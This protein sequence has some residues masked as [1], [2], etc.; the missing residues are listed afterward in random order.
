MPLN[1]IGT[2]KEGL[3]ADA[4][5]LPHYSRSSAN[6]YATISGQSVPYA[7]YTIRVAV[8]PC[9]ALSANPDEAI[10]ACYCNAL[11]LA[12]GTDAMHIAVPVIT[13]EPDAKPGEQD[14]R[15]A[16]GSVALF[17]KDKITE[18][19]V[20]LALPKIDSFGA[21]TKLYEDVGRYVSEA[22]S[23]VGI[24][25]DACGWGFGDDNYGNAFDDGFGKDES[26]SQAD[27]FPFIEKPAE[28]K[29][30]EPAEETPERPSE[31]RG[32]RSRLIRHLTDVTDE[33]DDTPQ[34]FEVNNFALPRFAKTGMPRRCI[35]RKSAAFSGLRVDTED[36]FSKRLRR[37][38]IAKGM[39]DVAV[40]K[41]ANLSRQHWSKII[42]NENYQP[43]KRT[44]VAL[45]VSLRL[46]LDETKDLLLSAGFALS[47]SF[48]FDLVIEYF[49]TQQNYDIYLINE[50]LFKYEQPLLG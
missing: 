1:Y 42:S 16:I 47:R 50:V 38:V 6:A 27:D 18:P 29:E 30:D 15:I 36:S 14:V 21:G 25:G 23:G 44:V 8:S 32:K 45:A 3:Y 12:Y 31:K 5:V 48:T 46:N 41:R 49:I 19:T 20:Y 39:D 24:Y 43:S 40:Y 17:L 7:D 9:E 10:K 22:E 26:G 13:A 4:A 11:E 2:E 28:P 33:P 37:F 34:R 35:S